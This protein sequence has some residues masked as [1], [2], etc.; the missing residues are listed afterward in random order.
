MDS[1]EGYRGNGTVQEEAEKITR[2]RVASLR[3]SPENGHLYDRNDK[4]IQEF[5][6]KF[7]IKKMDPLV[8]TQDNFIVSGHRRHAV[9]TL[10]GTVLV[11]CR[12]LPLRRGDTPKDEY[13][14]LLRDYNRHRDKTVAEKVR[15]TL[16]DVDPDQAYLAL[17]TSRFDSVYGAELNGVEVLE[18]EGSKR[19]YGISDDKADHVKYVL[20]IV[21]ERRPYWPLSVRGV[22][23]PLL[24]YQFVRGYY[25]PRKHEPDHGI[26]RTL[27]YKNDQGSYDATSD[28]ITRLRLSGTIP[29]AAFD[30]PTRPV[31]EFRAFK[32]VR[33]F[34]KQE[35]GGL[36]SGYWRNLLQSQPN[37]IECLVEKNTVYHM[38]LKVTNRYQITTRS[39]RGFNSIDS[40]YDISEA[41]RKSGKERLILIV[42]S[43]YDPEGQMILHD[44]GR[45]LRDDFGVRRPA[46]IPAGVTR[47]QIEEY[48][49]Q[50]MN[51][52]K[53]DSSNRDWFVE[54]NGGDETVWE[55]EALEP[56]D[57]LEDLD[58]VARSVLDID[59]FNRELAEERSE[60]AYLAASRRTAVEA[61][62][63]L[64]Q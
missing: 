47:Q 15:E 63:G 42:L 43:D 31:K 59:L 35:V 56:D 57:M 45:R 25:W 34:I 14:A 38:A 44:A 7:D 49:L 41:F 10:R 26:K 53:E 46:I 19:R 13:V 50:P 36:F 17:R 58:R 52:A 32:N 40:L 24:N 27:Y 29:W 16:V 61:L 12:V 54:R 18:I 37:H 22:H 33:D 11:N 51:F 39:A 8:V 5:N 64:D 1:K 28:L 9:L 3:P 23:Y 20:Q 62:R 60:A 6:Q 2:K 4:D 30:D 55:C 21:E 48:G